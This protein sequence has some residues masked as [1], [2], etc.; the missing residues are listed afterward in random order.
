MTASTSV[1]VE[2]GPGGRALLRTADSI[3]RQHRPADGIVLVKSSAHPSAPLVESVVSRLRAVVVEPGAH[4][5]TAWN[6]AARCATGQYLVVLPAGL[7]LHDSFLERCESMLHDVAPL[8]AVAPAI[9]LRSADGSGELHWIPEGLSP[10]AILT[11]TRSVPPAF[12][13]RREIW[14]S[15]GGF[16]EALEGLVE[17]EFWLR[18]AVAGHRIELLHEPLISREVAERRSADSADDERHLQLFRTVL[19]RHAAAVERNM[20]EL[21]VLREIRFGRLRDVHRGLLASRDADLEELD[22]LRIATAHHLAYL[23]HHGRD[24]VDWGDLRRTDPVSRDWGYDR[25]TPIDRRYIEEFLA[26][27]SYGSWSLVVGSC[28]STY[29]LVLPAR[30]RT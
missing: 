15:L 8:A 4:P 3:A 17:Y 21:L 1:L 6:A 16:D 12:A 14:E 2:V 10:A 27:H 9:E 30:S 19:E 7:A 11:D 20:T 13:I 23:T 24:G 22:R 5:G 29:L 25:G 26:A 18:L 28:Q